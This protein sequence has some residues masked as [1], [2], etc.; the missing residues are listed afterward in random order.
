MDVGIYRYGVVDVFD[1]EDLL[2]LKNV[3]KVTKCLL[4][5]SKLVSRRLLCT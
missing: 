3:A 5:L 2:A 1:A 4:Q